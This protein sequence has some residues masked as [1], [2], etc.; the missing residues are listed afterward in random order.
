[1]KWLLV[2]ISTRKLLIKDEHL[3]AKLKSG[4]YKCTFMD[5][6]FFF[7]S[8]ILVLIFGLSEDFKSGAKKIKVPVSRSL[9]SVE[10]KL[11]FASFFLPQNKTLHSPAC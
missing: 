10:Y 9:S 7:G 8:L 5:G 11:P 2:H 3:A 4:P 1:M 6:N